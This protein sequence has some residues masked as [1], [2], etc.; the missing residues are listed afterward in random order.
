M[1]QPPRKKR[2]SL[3][4]VGGAVDTAGD[5]AD[6]ARLARALDVAPSTD[7]D[8]D[9]SRTHVHGFHTY[10]ARLHPTTA[11]RL[12][13]AFAPPGG[14][15][16]DPFC[17]SGTVLVEAMIAGRRAV[18][19]DLNPLAVRLA[20]C[21]TRP[22]TPAELG[23]LAGAA[24]GCAAKADERRKAKAGA[25]RRFPHEDVA[26]FEPHVLLEL[27]SL[28]AGVEQLKDDPARVDLS[29]VLSA[30][31]VK[32]SRKRGDT[33]AATATRRLAP[34]FAAKL[35]VQKADDLARRLGEFTARLPTPWPPPAVVTQDDATVLRTLPP[36]P[37]TAVVTSPPYA[38]TYDYREHHALRLR[39]LGL[40]ASALDRGELGSRTAFNKLPPPEAPAAWAAELGRFFRAAGWVVPAGTPVVLVLADSAVGGVAL[41]ADE[42]AADAARANGFVPAARAS[43]PRP[44]F[45][46]P[47]AAAFR[48]RPRAEHA[49]LFR[50]G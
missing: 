21:K 32:L 44:H 41:R 10:P 22:R 50:K 27:D 17:G 11:A 34:G 49:L 33:S 38:A 14:T 42:L 40:D 46:G 13:A 25:T 30:V 12:V 6:A 2:R 26:L 18:G 15:V 5:P 4:H 47:T 43:Q 7:A 1:S 48:T 3:S 37:V 36:G 8:D 29:L 28:R 31:L 16:L 20:R 39:W 35:F 19:T 45:H 9:P 24:R 23:H